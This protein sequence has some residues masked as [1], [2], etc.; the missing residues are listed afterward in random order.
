MLNLDEK[1]LGD[2]LWEICCN[3]TVILPSFGPY[4]AYNEAFYQ[5]MIRNSL[6]TELY[7]KAIRKNV[8]D[9]VVVEIGTG[10]QLIW[11]LLCV[12][13]GAKKIYAIEVNETAYQ[14]AKQLAEQKG[15]TEKIELI[16]GC[17]TDINL[18]EKADI[19]I[20]EIIGAIGNDEGV[21]GYLNDA[22]RFLKPN[23]MMIPESCFTLLSPG[24]KPIESYSDDFIED[25]A[26]AY[27]S[28]VH[29]K[30]GKEINFTR[31]C[32]YNLPKSYIV[33]PPQIFEDM[34]FNDAVITEEFDKKLNFKIEKTTNFD[35][36][37]LWINLYFDPENMLSPFNSKFRGIVYI[38]LEPF[39][40]EK[41]DLLEVHCRSTIS[42]NGFNPNYF[43][44]TFVKRDDEVI[45]HCF[46]ESYY[47]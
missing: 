5:F 30:M 40:L 34:Y 24:F 25:F 38:P 47:V 21:A 8:K 29:H 19:C 17:S 37:F 35:G 4:R 11:S 15:L 6:R 13:A 42:A 27:T 14:A 12:E 45:Y 7:E 18:P 23:G 20:S 36:L 3:N 22:K 44:D 16:L 9:K 43:F 2:K 1:N 33:A 26:K 31:Y 32:V 41:D 10:A 28:N 46:R 39:A